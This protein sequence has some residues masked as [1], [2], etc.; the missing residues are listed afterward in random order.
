[1]RICDVCEQQVGETQ[2][3][4]KFVINS[5][6]VLANENKID[7]KTAE[8]VL[9]KIG[10]KKTITEK[11]VDLGDICRNCMSE[12]TKSLELA[13]S[14]YSS[15]MAAEMH[16][17]LAKICRKITKEELNRAFFAKVTADIR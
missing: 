6:N 4:D 12:A 8:W 10:A 5:V 16:G 17:I 13:Y 3:V 7:G 15:L 1:M 14:K 11:P 9:D 2:Y